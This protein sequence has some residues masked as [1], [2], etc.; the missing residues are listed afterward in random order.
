LEST[1]II[2]LLL[3]AI[4]RVK[5]QPIRDRDPYESWRTALPGSRLVKVL[6]VFQMIQ[7]PFLRGL[8]RAIEDHPSLQ[9]AL[10]GVVARNTLSNALEQRDLDQMVE[11][12]VLLLATYAPWVERLGKKFAR[13][14]VVDATQIKLSLQAYCWAEYRK[15]SGAAKLSAVLDWARGIPQQLVVTT[16][17]VHDRDRGRGL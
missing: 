14:A 11:A 13:I 15:R 2:T 17:K 9:R 7:S 5:L 6:V 16:G 10:G 3:R 4:D 8:V 1:T 12:W